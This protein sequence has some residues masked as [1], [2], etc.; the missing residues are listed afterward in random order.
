MVLCSLVYTF[1]PDIQCLWN[2]AAIPMYTT[3]YQRDQDVSVNGS[4]TGRNTCPKSGTNITV[5]NSLQE[6][7]Q[8]S[9][10]QMKIVEIVIKFSTLNFSYLSVVECTQSFLLSIL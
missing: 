1:T 6:P 4:S 3:A 8:R 7:Q 9:K 10:Y 2:H 5:Q